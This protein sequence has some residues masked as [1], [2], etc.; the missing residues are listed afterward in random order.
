MA[1]IISLFNQ[2]G[3]VGKTT[4]TMNLGYQLALMDKKVLLVDIDPQSSLTVFMGLNPFQL[5][6][7]MYDA[8]IYEEEL[9]IHHDI[10]QLDLAPSNII[11]SK[12]DFELASAIRREDRL[13][14]ALEPHLEYYDFILIDCPPSL[15]ILSIMSLVASTYLLI[16]IQTE[17][18]AV[19]GTILL[20][21]T[22]LEMVQ[23][24][25]KKLRVAG[26]IP[27]MY[28]ARTS[29]GVK[30]LKY[31]L[32]IFEELREHQIFKDSTAYPVIPRRTDFADA[33]VSH[34]PLA[35]Y[36]PRQSAIKQLNEIALGLEELQ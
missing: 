23:K 11:L 4:L 10:H 34:Q 1:K 35:L 14:S 21:R 6:K 5:E 36:A 31:I 22:I 20:L 2:S 13:I 29:Q 3:G 15:G 30:T 28:D 33:S 9:P 26:I 19:E 8:I 25:N 27:T 18:K 7:T 12:A 16:P 17:Y 32:D 24:A